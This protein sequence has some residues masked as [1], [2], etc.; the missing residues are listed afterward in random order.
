MLKHFSIFTVVIAIMLVSASL[1][2]ADKIAPVAAK[3]SADNTVTVPLEITNQDGLMA[4]DIPIRFS[5]GVT[6]KEVN[7]ENTRVSYFDLKIANIDN[8]DNTVVVGLVT[9][10]TPEPKP[11]LAAGTGSVANLVFQVDDPSV[12]EITLEA[13]E[14]QRPHHSMTFIYLPPDRGE[15]VGQT[16]S[17]PEFGTVSVSLSGKLGEDNLPT[18]YSLAQ[19]YPNPFNPTATIPFSLKEGGEWKVTIYNVT[20]QVVEEIRGY[21]EAGH[22][23]VEWD[24]SELA[25]GI[26]FYKL[27]AGSFKATKKAVLLK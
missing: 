21:A 14:T 9:Q 24:A 12:S 1:F 5:D 26:Y 20:G 16:R 6:L 3:V 25:S 23:D 2:A 15:G 19:N 11:M 27:E 18:S 7:F 4:I 17:T 8:D 22:V 10:T 13:L